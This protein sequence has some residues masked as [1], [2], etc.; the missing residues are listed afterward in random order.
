[1]DEEIFPEMKKVL[2]LGGGGFIGR[3]IVEYLVNRKDC[4]ITAADLREG[5]NW[6]NISSH[7]GNSKF[8]KPVVDDFSKLHAFEQFNQQFDEI[9]MLAAIVGVNRTLKN[10]A[11]VIEV[12][13]KL[14]TNLLDWVE[15]NP[16]QRI[17]FSSSSENY[18]AT[19]DLFDG[20]IPTSEEIPL[21]IGDVTH[22][23][24]TYAITKI[25]GE[26]SFIH[27]AKKLGYEWRIVRYQKYNWS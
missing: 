13:T 24:W 11:D 1:M 5:S 23:R 26:S 17:L 25:H 2:V 3:N 18:A 12:N 19:T 15:N 4:H 20:E 14:T 9:Y 21:C 16:V 27:S 6:S 10:P 22:P 7:L 8:F